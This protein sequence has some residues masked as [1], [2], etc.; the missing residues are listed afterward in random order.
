MMYITYNCIHVILPYYLCKCV[1]KIWPYNANS[2]QGQHAKIGT[3]LNIDPHS[4]V[5]VKS[6]DR[7]LFTWTLILFNQPYQ[8]WFNYLIRQSRSDKPWSIMHL[9]TILTHLSD[10]TLLSGPNRVGCYLPVITGTGD[11]RWDPAIYFPSYQFLI[12]QRDENLVSYSASI[13]P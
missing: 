3:Y 12:T 7:M 4:A 6:H 9:L 13:T 5:L 10:L 11:C 1:D 8:L 2:S